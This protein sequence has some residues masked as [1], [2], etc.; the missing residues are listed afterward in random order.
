MHLYGSYLLLGL[1]FLQCVHTR[2][3]GANKVLLYL[4]IRRC[5]SFLSSR[6]QTINCFYKGMTQISSMELVSVLLEAD[7]D[8]EAISVLSP[9]SDSVSRIGETFDGKKPW[10]TDKN[11]KLK[12]CYI[13]KSKGSTEA[14]VDTIFPLVRETLFLETIQRQVRPKKRIPKRELHKRVR[15]LDDHQSGQKLTEQRGRFRNKKKDEL[16]HRLLELN[17]KVMNQMMILLEP[18]LPN[19]LKD[20]ELL[21]VIIDLCRGLVLIQRY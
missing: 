1:C 2:N 3:D 5:Y 4:K 18:P 11:I 9:P 15:V 10:W 17:G 14:F 8:D 16:Q 7:K 21:M 20:E 19:L 13:Y 6:T 12:L